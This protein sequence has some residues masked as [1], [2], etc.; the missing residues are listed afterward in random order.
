M[1]LDHQM[2]WDR[3]GGD[4]MFADGFDEAFVGIVHRAGKSVACYDI[5]KCLSVLQ[6]RDGMNFEEAVEYLEFNLLGAYVG[7]GTP[8][9]LEYVESVESEV[10]E[11]EGDRGYVGPY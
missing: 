11:Q 3:F 6:E 10:Q 2:I 1:M 9:F 8:C 4:V 5:A 7:E